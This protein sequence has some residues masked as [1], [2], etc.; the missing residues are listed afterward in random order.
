MSDTMEPDEDKQT[1]PICEHNTMLDHCESITCLWL[2]CKNPECM[3]V[4]DLKLFIGHKVDPARADR[5][6]RLVLT[7]EG[8]WREHI[9]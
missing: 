8:E 9:A 1:C 5:R 3:A 2:K 4:L 7:D 6:T